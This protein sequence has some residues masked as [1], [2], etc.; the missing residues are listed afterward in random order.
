MISDDQMQP[1]FT[2]EVAQALR[3]EA[4]W[5]LPASDIED[6]VVAAIQ[7][8]ATATQV[9]DGRWRVAPLAAAAALVV[10]GLLAGAVVFSSRGD[11][12]VEYA[13]DATELA[14]TASGMIGLRS[15]STGLDVELV[16]QGLEPAAPDEYYQ[17]WVRTALGDVVTIGTFHLRGEGESVRLWAGLDLDE[18]VA[19]TITLQELGEG[20]A[21]SGRVVLSANLEAG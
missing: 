7:R 12:R 17:G 10:L 15:T 21:S 19:L 11:T 20:P 14:P 16:V 1:D 8:E 13:L 9:D 18:V 4:T 3:D 6:R 2:G 5:T